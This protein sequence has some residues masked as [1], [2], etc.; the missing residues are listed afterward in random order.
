MEVFW[1]YISKISIMN[2]LW[3]LINSYFFFIEDNSIICNSFCKIFN[4]HLTNF[5]IGDVW[6]FEK[7]YIISQ[8]LSKF[9]TD[10]LS[11]L[12]KAV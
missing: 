6:L 4:Q 5:P 1:R 3:A 7:L 8:N 9:T 12:H 11:Y 10:H 2:F